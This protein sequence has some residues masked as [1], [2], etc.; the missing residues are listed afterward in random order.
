MITKLKAPVSVKLNFN[1][2]TRTASPTEI[3]WEGRTYKIKK[4]GMHHTY[5]DG[6]TLK[7]VFSC[8]ANNIF[9]RLVFNTENLHWQLEE[10]ADGLPN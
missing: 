3:I 10:I 1:H 2:K 7:H 5:R 9:F 6:R 4:I 8:I